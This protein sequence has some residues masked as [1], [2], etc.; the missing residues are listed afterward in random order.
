MFAQ[1]TRLGVYTLF[2]ARNARMHSTRF[3]SD[4]RD[5]VNQG[6]LGLTYWPPCCSSGLTITSALTLHRLS[7]ACCCIAIYDGRY[8]VQG[9]H[10][11]TRTSTIG[12]LPGDSIHVSRRQ[13]ASVTIDDETGGRL[14]VTC[15]FAPCRPLYKKLITST[16]C[17]GQFFY[18]IVTP[19]SECDC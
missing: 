18:L 17:V 10:G 1:Y 14:T 12:G 6:R 2:T 19:R 16:C 5:T 3:S 7:F 8:F 13:G 15:I 9:L 4:R 11:P